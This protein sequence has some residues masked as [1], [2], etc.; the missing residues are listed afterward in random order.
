MRSSKRV[1]YIDKLVVDDESE[2]ERRMRLLDFHNWY[3]LIQDHTFF[4]K[5][6]ELTKEDCE[7]ILE[8]NKKT[9]AG[10]VVDEVIV[11]KNSTR[12]RVIRRTSQS[13]ISNIMS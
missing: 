6:F 1:I 12:L 9:R 10:E 3:H 7:N 2:Y 4:S 13:K 8:M 11:Q 5:S